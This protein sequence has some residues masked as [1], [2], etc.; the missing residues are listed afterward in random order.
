MFFTRLLK[1]LTF[2]DLFIYVVNVACF[3]FVFWKAAECII[4]FLNN[5]RGTKMDIWYTEYTDSFPAITI[6]SAAN[7]DGGMR[8]NTE[9][10]K[11][12]GISGLVTARVGGTG[13]TGDP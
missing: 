3:S 12:C 6:C 13:G 1:Q 8:W 7:N 4:K 11:Q 10:L 9:H 2:Y 5:P